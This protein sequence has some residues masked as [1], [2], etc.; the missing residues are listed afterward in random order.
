MRNL[1]NFFI[2]YHVLFLFLTLEFI[3]L[4]FIIRYNNFHQV[5]MLNSSNILS[6]KFYEKSHAV[7]EYFSLRK[8]NT[9][10]AEENT[11]LRQRL[12]SVLLSD[13]DRS[14]EI[15]IGE[16]KVTAISAKVINNSVNKQYN[17]IT[18]NRGSKDGIHP[19]MGILCNAGVVGVIINVSENYSTA[20]SVLNGR[21][22]LNAKLESSNYFGPLRWEGTNPYVAVLE[23]IPYHVKVAENEKVITSGYSATFPEG[24]LIGQVIKVEHKEGNS[25]QKIWVQLSTD[26]K[27]LLYVEVIENVTKKEQKELEALNNDE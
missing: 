9:E 2:K 25:F 13:V 12:Q 5:K 3:S 15:E 23:E 1:L 19:D 16:N 14:V 26:F 8:T 24:I 4:T 17:Y 7:A 20:L 22:S 11:S 27:N 6:G 10:L 21:W 18:L